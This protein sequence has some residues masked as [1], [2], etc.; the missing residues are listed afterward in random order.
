[1]PK[2]EPVPVKD[3]KIAL[4]HDWLLGRAGAERHFLAVCQLYPGAT[5]YTSAYCPG[6]TLPQFADFNIK[7]GWVGRL[8][9]F[10]RHHRTALFWR[11]LYYL[12]LDLTDYN[13]II[14]SSGSEA[15]AVASKGHQLHINI[16]Y[17]PTHYYF[18]HYRR[19]RANP[20]LG[21]L[22]FLAKIMLPVLVKPMRA[23]DRW[24]A[25]RPDLM[26]AISQV[27]ADRIKHYYNRTS[28]VIYPPAIKTPAVLAKNRPRSGYLVIGRQ[29]AYKNFDLAIEA[30]NRLNRPLTVVGSGPESA[31]LRRL[32]GDSIKFTGFVSELDKANLLKTARG[33]IFPGV[34]D[35]GIVMVEA[36]AA[37]TPVIALAAG[38]AL[39]VVEAGRTGIFFAKPTVTDLVAALLEFE[40]QKLSPRDCQ[41]RARQ[42]SQAKFKNDFQD[43]VEKSWHQFYAAKT[44]DNH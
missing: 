30:C 39:E 20:G 43:F 17:S 25:R 24:A 21:S 44:K 29:V 11:W 22:N 18:S 8:P 7:A 37:G 33:L 31:R 41:L 28:Q 16:C 27:V 3:L 12:R 1:M 34:D 6:K 2:K 42:F 13:L 10:G 26:V 4:V 38:G 23:L 35:F 14:S 36:L 32:A 5:V 9:Y 15:K 19:Y 40:Q